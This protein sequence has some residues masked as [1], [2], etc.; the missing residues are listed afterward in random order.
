MLVNLVVQR[1]ARVVGVPV[2]VVCEGAVNVE[3]VGGGEAQARLVLRQVPV[4]GLGGPDHRPVLR[5]ELLGESPDHV[6]PNGVLPV[7]VPLNAHLQRRVEVLHPE[8]RPQLGCQPRPLVQVLGPQVG[9]VHDH[10][11]PRRKGRT[12][13]LPLDTSDRVLLLRGQDPPTL[14]PKDLG[15]QRVPARNQ[16]VPLGVGLHGLSPRGLTRPRQPPGAN[17]SRHSFSFRRCTPP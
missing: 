1:P 9:V 8:P 17:Q 10:R 12:H 3:N 5:R 7:P 4:R 13:D 15:T 16:P 2:P 6:L 14:Q 11:P